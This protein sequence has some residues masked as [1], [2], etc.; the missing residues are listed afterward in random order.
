MQFREAVDADAPVIAA[1]VHSAYRGDTS[2]QGWTS[3]ADLLDG[4]RILVQDVRALIAE[5]QAVVLL[6][7]DPDDSVLACCELRASRDGVAYFGMF[8]VQPGR[9]GGG[10][11]RTVMAEAERYAVERWGVT[12]MEMSV[13]A[14]RTDLTA[15]YERMGYARTGE[16]KP[17]PYGDPR[18]GAPRRDDL[19]FEVLAKDLR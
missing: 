12:T 3:E 15:W 19:Y 16:T 10:V 2:R 4:D 14:Q 1:L 5:P 17:F 6:G 18:F 11:G 13:I 9:T 8:A 7:L